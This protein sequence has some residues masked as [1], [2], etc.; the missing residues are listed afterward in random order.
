MTTIIEPYYD[1]RGYRRTGRTVF[2]LRCHRTVYT[3]HA[4]GKPGLSQAEMHARSHEQLGCE[5]NETRY[6]DHQA[7]TAYRLDERTTRMIRLGTA[8][9][10]NSP[11]AGWGRSSLARTVR[12]TECNAQVY[13]TNVGAADGGVRIVEIEAG[14]HLLS[15]HLGLL[16]RID[17]GALAFAHLEG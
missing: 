15:Q 7:L 9:R 6:S 13:R 5:A 12:C 3:T 2:C 11:I 16:D 1:M 8:T 14:K 10:G 17:P 4:P